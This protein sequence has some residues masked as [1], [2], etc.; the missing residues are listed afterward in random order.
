MEFIKIFSTRIHYYIHYKCACAGLG[1][2]L[3]I[4]EKTKNKIDQF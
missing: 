1:T 4:L 2:E 3:R